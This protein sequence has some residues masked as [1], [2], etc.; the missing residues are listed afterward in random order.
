M[1]VVSL[2]ILYLYYLILIIF[3]RQIFPNFTSRPSSNMMDVR[4]ALKAQAAQ[5]A[6]LASRSS[7]SCLVYICNAFFILFCSATSTTCDSVRC[8][9]INTKHL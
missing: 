6:A 9:I 7:L 4:K 3:C 2:I 1:V 8:N 5:R